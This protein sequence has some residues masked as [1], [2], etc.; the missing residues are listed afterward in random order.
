MTREFLRS[1]LPRWERVASRV[2]VLLALLIGGCAP[3]APR[4]ELKGTA[5]DGAYS[6]EVAGLSAA[7]LTVFDKLEP[8][9]RA[10]VLQVLVAGDLADPPAVLGS[11]ARQGETLRFTPRFPLEPGLRYRAVFH[12]SQGR[13]AETADLVAEFQIPPR[14]EQ[15]ATRVTHIYPSSDRLPENQLKFYI[16]FSAPM[17]RGDAYRHV[18]LL[19]AEGRELEATF[20]ELGE[21]LWDRELR[22]FTLLCDPGRVKRGLKP[23]EDLGPVLQAGQRYTLLVDADWLDA[24]GSPLHEATRKSFEVLA[25]DDEPLDT[26]GWKLEAPPANTNDEL[27]VRFSE[28][29]DHALVERMLWVTTAAGEKIAGTG[30]TTDRETCW[31]FRPAQSWTAGAYYLVVDT[32]LEDLAGNSISRAFD[33]D[34]LAKPEKKIEA[35]TISFPFM[36]EAAR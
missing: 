13:A 31:R 17:G 3:A 8:A 6:F 33:S 19:D 11:V 26:T 14:P 22:R 9:A 24:T 36:V 2:A 21:E 25:S 32:A 18:H 27:V 12:R 35:K 10:G 4:I 15:A 28:P 1:A 5:E 34:L 20:L 29:L 7:E 16:H 30:E 23:R